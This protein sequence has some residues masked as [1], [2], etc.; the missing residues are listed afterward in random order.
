MNISGIAN[1]TF[2]KCR[3]WCIPIFIMGVGK[4]SWPMT[5]LSTRCLAVLVS[6]CPSFVQ[7]ASSWG[8]AVTIH[9]RSVLCSTCWLTR[10]CSASTWGATVAN[11]QREIILLKMYFIVED[12]TR[13]NLFCP[14]S[15]NINMLLYNYWKWNNMKIIYGNNILYI[16]T[17]WFYKSKGEY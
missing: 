14:Y 9:W 13:I 3:L 12:I 2:L 15:G 11:T 8:F 5:Y 16:D 6:L 17:T 10:W 7:W 4:L 1:C